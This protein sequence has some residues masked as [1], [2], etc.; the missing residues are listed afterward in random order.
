MG[1]TSQKASK[2]IT[3]STSGR[4]RTVMAHV[5]GLIRQLGQ[6]LRAIIKGIMIDVMDDFAALDR[7]VGVSLIPYVMASGDVATAIYG[8][9]GRTFGHWQWHPPMLV[10][11]ATNCHPPAA[12]AGTWPSDPRPDCRRHPARSSV[13]AGSRTERRG[14]ASRV[15]AVERRRADRTYSSCSHSCS[16]SPVGGGSD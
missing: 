8:R 16:V 1:W 10:A 3:W 14:R 7:V 15:N 6:I 9:M 4:D 13:G 2:L 12:I 11:F 5:S